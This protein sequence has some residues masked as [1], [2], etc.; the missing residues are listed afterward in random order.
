M[1]S[2]LS[3]LLVNLNEKVRTDVLIEAIWGNGRSPRA[4]A[5]L[6][7]LLW[8]LRRVL[9]PGRPA[10]TSS[11]LLR[12][13]EQGY[14]LAIPPEAV[15]SWQFDA[16]ARRLN[17]VGA[18]LEA[19]AILDLTAS[20]M[21]LWRGRPYDDVDDDGW[22]DPHRNRLLEQ[23]LVVQEARIGALLRVGQPEQAVAELVPILVEHPFVERLWGYRILALDQ[24]GRAAAALEAY[25]E[26]GRLL[27]RELG[28][29]P[30]PD[31]QALQEQILRHER[32]LAGP[33]PAPRATRGVVRVP[34]HRT[35]LVGREKDVDAVA[36]LLRRHRLISMTG[37]VGCGKTRLAAAVAQQ[38]GSRFPDGVCFVDLSDVTGDA[39]VADRVQETLHLEVDATDSATEAIAGLVADREML[40]VLDNCEQVTSAARTLAT[41]VLER[42]GRTRVLVTSRRVLG[43]QDEVVY[44][45]R[46]LELP[47]SVSPEDLSA[48]PAV[49]LFV[50][51]AAGH[52]ISVDLSGPHGAAVAQICQAVDGL[53]LG[54]ELAAA[55]AQVFQLHEVAASVSA[56]P[57]S[58]GA[59]TQIP[60]RAGE[61][62]LGESIE[63]SYSVLT[64]HERIAHRRLSVLPPGFTLEAAVAV[65]AGRYLPADDVSTALIGLARQSLLEATKPE[66]PGGP[67]L[68]RQL[69]PIRAHAAQQL[70]EAGEA[71]AV[72]D[73][74]LRWLSTTLADGPR[75]GQSDGGALDRRL[76]DNRRTITAT[77]EAAIAAAP[78]D[79]VLITLCRLVP[80]WWLDGKLSP[81]TV[82]LVSAAV[83]AVGPGNSDFAAAAVDAAHSSF[84]ALTQETAMSEPSL[85]DAIGRLRDAPADL[86]IFAA[87]LLLAVAAACWTGG[88]MVAANAAADA[89]AAYGELLDDDHVRVLAKAVRCAMDLATNP[90]AAGATARVVLEECRALGNAAAEIMC[91][92]TLYM[93][94]LFTQNGPEGLRWSAEAIRCQQEIGQRNA[95]TTLEARGSLYLLAGNP[96]DAIRCY[97]SA[98]LQYSRLGRG[99]PQIPGT[100]E[101]LAAARS[102]VST[103]EFNTAWAS[104]ERLAASDLIGAWI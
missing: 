8:R 12:T 97:G 89:V 18:P 3:V 56:H 81:E 21:A 104:G 70:A 82:R 51:R 41:A 1:A 45:V 48:S 17:E 20:A 73:T 66:R 86:A 74:L 42:D 63:S 69:V 71:D 83:A 91:Y 28:L 99:W 94:A 100:D 49:T 15:D 24:S 80:Y 27:D 87:E 61:L 92:H 19:A 9:D 36:G 34:R 50:E 54:I 16:A 11:M 93:A 67:S 44:G 5:A 85:L 32:S 4:P 95:A 101:F 90:A 39:A 26:V 76:E 31:L 29:R 79:D 14:R 60:R 72:S 103:E 10:R 59:A 37:P 33:T 75:I 53:P 58:L 47:E 22:L 35:T 43:A 7:T 68:F 62:T 78:S 46:P 25:A 84:L 40:I 13:E 38:V 65:C 88:E 2:A 23:R 30:G 6:D 96:Q 55:R 102:Q 52:G 57:T 64:E 98:N 77:L